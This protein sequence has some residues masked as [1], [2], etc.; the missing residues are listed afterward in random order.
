MSI[1]QHL[2]KLVMLKPVEARRSILNMSNTKVFLEKGL[3]SNDPN[4]VSCRKYTSQAQVRSILHHITACTH[5][6]SFCLG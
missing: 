5:R 4:A 1:P 3:G 6:T 2:D